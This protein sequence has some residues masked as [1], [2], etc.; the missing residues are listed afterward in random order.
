MQPECFVETVK[1][2]GKHREGMKSAGIWLTNPN[3]RS[4]LLKNVFV[5]TLG[6]NRTDR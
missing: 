6:G 1:N 4:E 5:K 3:C 2:H